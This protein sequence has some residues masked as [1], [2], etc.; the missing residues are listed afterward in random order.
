MT[1]ARKVDPI[2]VEDYLAGELVSPIKHEYRG[3][4]VYAMAGGRSLHNQIATNITVAVGGRL[5]GKQCRPYNSDMKVRVPAPPRERFFYPDASVVCN[6]IEPE[7]SYLNEPVVLFEVLSK[8]TR[9]I[10]EGEK[11]DGYLTIHSLGLYVLVE[12]ESALVVVYR[13]RNAE[14]VREVYD[15]LSMIVRMPEIDIE[16]PLAEIYDR[17]QFAPEPDEDDLA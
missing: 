11:L 1:V 5:R 7:A 16:L 15:G 4:F 14:F 10:D 6:S 2:S 17:V 13:R 3:G 8:A 12:Q 9:R